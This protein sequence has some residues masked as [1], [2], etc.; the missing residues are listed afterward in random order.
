MA[1]IG[2]SKA[3]VIICQPTAKGDNPLRLDRQICVTLY[4]ASNC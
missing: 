1:A 2:S 3:C 4:G